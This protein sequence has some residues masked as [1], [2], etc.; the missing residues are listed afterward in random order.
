M[1]RTSLK[2]FTLL[3]LSLA[4][5]VLLADINA[6]NEALARGDYAGASKE[7]RRLAEAGDAKAQTHLGYMY[8]VGE[9]VNQ[10]YSEAVRWYRKAAVQGDKDAQYN[11]AV[12]YAF[13]EGVTQ[14]Y[15][16][17]ATWYRRAAEQGHDVAQYSLALSYTYG[18]GVK[19]DSAEAIKWYRKSAEQGYARAQ[20]Q[21]ASKYHT[22]DGVTLDY[23]EAVKWYRAAADR[24]N[25][26]AQY[27]LGSMFRAGRGV[28]QDYNQALRWYRMAADQ[29]YAAATNELASLERV[30]AGAAR[31]NSRPQLQPAP[32][33]P[34]ASSEPE[35]RKPLVS[36][37]KDDLLVLENKDSDSTDMGA[38]AMDDSA[39]DSAADE[40]AMADEPMESDSDEAV[41]VAMDDAME[42]V[43]EPQEKKGIG[44][45]FRKFFSKKEPLE[46]TVTETALADVEDET[47]SE[48]P[49]IEDSSELLG[50]S[51]AE[52][53]VEDLG[54]DLAVEET[55]T[56][57]LEHEVVYSEEPEKK[58]RFGFFGK[59]FGKKD[60][61]EQPEIVAEVEDYSL[62]EDLTEETAMPET[63][64]TA[65]ES[66]SDTAESEDSEYWATSTSWGDQNDATTDEQIAELE[67]E[68]K[69]DRDELEIE[70]GEKKRGF[71]SRLF[72]KKDNEPEST[73]ESIDATVVDEQTIAMADETLDEPLFDDDYATDDAATA[74]AE[75]TE[76]LDNTDEALADTEPQEK[77]RGFFS[78]L[79]G[80]KQQSGEVSEEETLA[81]ADDTLDQPLFDEPVAESSEEVVEVI[82]ESTG[83][84]VEEAQPEQKKGF[85]GRL[86]GGNRDSES[87]AE[88]VLEQDLYAE[89][90][91]SQEQIQISSPDFVAEASVL[92]AG[93]TALSNAE[94][95]TAVATF[96]D[97]AVQGDPTAQYE[98]GRLYHQG[99][100][101]SQNYVEAAH[102]YRQSAKQGN[103][104]AQYSLGNMFLM[105][106][107]VDQND[108]SA[109]AWYE[110]A[111]DQGHVAARHNVSN[112]D[113][114]ADKRSMPVEDIEAA[115][116][117][118]QSDVAAD[119]AG[120]E[121]E[122]E[123]KKG[124]FGRLFGNRDT[125]EDAWLEENTAET[126]GPLPAIQ[127]EA[128]TA[129][130]DEVEE[131]EKKKGFFGRLFGSKDDAE[132]DETELSE[133]VVDSAVMEVPE[134]SSSISEPEQSFEEAIA[135]QQAYEK[136]LA[137]S[138]G[139]GVPQDNQAA[140]V[141][142]KKAAELGHS[143]AQYKTGVAYAYGEGVSKDLQQALG[144]YEK[145][146]K[147]GNVLAQRNLA[148]MYMNGDGVQQNKPLG[149]AWHS[150]VAD[151][152]NVM[153]V[154][155]RD[156]LQQ[157]LSESELAE[158]MVLKETLK[159]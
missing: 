138:F 16:E 74:E 116:E 89:E 13:G 139:D 10:D 95:E 36:V 61:T 80:K 8:Y 150:I 47:L 1:F 93:F 135:A 85:F 29:G 23:G 71:F 53:M 109:R 103:A 81:M 30:M 126:Q 9:G 143:Q 4:S 130:S 7:Y 41:D 142:F 39:M 28:T 52:V 57:Q 94:Y 48:S 17:A 125:D 20:V 49:D 24:G 3:S 105:G 97:L 140:F 114:M 155:R 119:T 66:G 27:N 56:E 153:D 151:Q 62:S 111:A 68:V 43:E 124:F 54:E 91:E 45:F 117:Q 113:R 5:S 67:S 78:R 159:R 22:G 101:V 33:R 76:A 120:G 25:A 123:K 58:S 106:E 154:H 38:E 88:E 59:L 32:Q 72:G 42:D 156:S 108:D 35:E 86:F 12:A 84:T 31:N 65:L 82:E 99:L 137:Y 18:E 60:E 107:G 121:V 128:E 110:L 70:S 55:G 102:W 146:A 129:S 63:E 37:D 152:G 26:A 11:L 136:G 96:E 14:D 46:E 132:V 158:A 157:Q 21:L 87:E 115:V 75:V 2:L 131:S 92:E 83:D 141:S 51:E 122:P 77:K 134:D 34:V 69:G 127:P 64:D 19:Q 145:A 104:D 73:E 149:F 15:K 50:D 133:T 112:L 147:K 40:I 44:G 118:E 148:I 79:F 90:P 100:G 144:W 98:L 6:A